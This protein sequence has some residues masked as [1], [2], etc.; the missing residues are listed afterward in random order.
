MI[1]DPSSSSILDDRALS[2]CDAARDA[3]EKPVVVAPEGLE[4]FDAA[5]GGGE[6]LRYV[7]L[8]A[9]IADRIANSPA[10]EH[11]QAAQRLVHHSGRDGHHHVFVLGV[12]V[13][14]LPVAGDRQRGLAGEIALCDRI[15]T[16]GFSHAGEFHHLVVFELEGVDQEHHLGRVGVDEHDVRVKGVVDQGG[17]GHGFV[18]AQGNPGNRGLEFLPV[19]L[20][21]A[22]TRCSG[23]FRP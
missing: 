9:G 7:R 12:A 1:G 22:P 6:G 16:G 2:G 19:L 11:L 17:H 4:L 13:A 14:S 15:R 10:V 3:Q 18:L 5:V 20:V 21:S 23:R 8:G